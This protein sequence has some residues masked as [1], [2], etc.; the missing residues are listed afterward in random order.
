MSLNHT[1]RLIND[2]YRSAIA[3]LVANHY[4]AKVILTK[5]NKTYFKD[6]IITTEEIKEFGEL[7]A[8]VMNNLSSLYCVLP[9]NLLGEVLIGLKQAGLTIKNV[10]TIPVINDYCQGCNIKNRTSYDE[11]KT[12]YAVFATKG[13]G[14]RKLTYST[15]IDP[16]GSC[17][18]PACFTWFKGSDI[19]A[20]ETLLKIS[21][22]HRD[23]VLD[24]FM[25]T[26]DIGEA[27][28]NADRHFTG[29][30]PDGGIFRA[31]SDR[32]DHVGE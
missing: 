19:Q 24:P 11:N 10:L 16:K 25:N 12:M 17:V 31:V 23:E 4:E 21:S 29:I 2:D 5:L 6:N 15:M 13:C 1:I 22:D 32:L 3:E 7:M 30:E 8:Q 27:A 20:Y 14:N 18:Y 28:I 9:S 26:G